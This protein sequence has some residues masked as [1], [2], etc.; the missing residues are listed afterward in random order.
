MIAPNQP[1]LVGVGR[2]LYRNGDSPE[3]A[4]LLAEAARKAAEDTG[5]RGVLDAI[6][7]IR[8]LHQMSGRYS[9][10]AALVANRLG[11]DVSHTMYTHQGG[12]MTQQLVHRT[13]DDITGGNVDVALIAGGEAWLTRHLLGEPS[14]W[15]V[16]TDTQPDEMFGTELEYTTASEQQLGIGVIEG[17][18]LVE[19]SVATHTERTMEE[20]RRAT[21]QIYSRFTEIAARNPHAMTQRPLTAEEIRTTSPNNR[22]LSYPYTKLT[23]SNERVDQ[24]GALIICSAEK[25]RSLGMPKDRWVFLHGGGE[26]IERRFLCQ[27]KDLAIS[28]ALAAAGRTALTLAG[29]GIDDIAHADL[30]SCFPSA[31]HVAALALG[32]GLDRDLTVTGGLAYS[33]GPWNAYVVQSLAGMTEVLRAD[34]GSYGLVSANGGYLTKHAIGVWSCHPPEAGTR[35]DS[36]QRE[37]DATVVPRELLLEFDGEAQLETYTVTYGRNGVPQRACVFALTKSGS[38]T[39]AISEDPSLMA[40]LIEKEMLGQMVKIRHQRLVDIT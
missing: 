3:P 32:L 31:V 9:N 16:Q 37:L 18:A 36:P 27:R 11:I 21:S 26:G 38:R 23:V 1:V 14:P 34:P 12:Q 24:A 2:V 10:P 40:S 25:A 28:P 33:G 29:I 17:Y 30:Y 8:V 13:C 39:M 15:D 6:G 19:G 22:W 7:S 35:W 4:E 5:G 20:Q